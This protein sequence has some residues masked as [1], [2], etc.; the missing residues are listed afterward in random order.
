MLERALGVDKYLMYLNLLL[1]I[2]G[3]VVVMVTALPQQQFEAV[4]VWMP[5]VAVPYLM[6]AKK[7]EYNGEDT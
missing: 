6:S 3:F 2:V 1:V 7:G 4:E 5:K